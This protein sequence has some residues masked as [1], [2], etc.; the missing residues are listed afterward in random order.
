MSSVASNPQFGKWCG[1]CVCWN[2]GFVGCRRWDS[3]EGVRIETLMD[4]GATKTK[5]ITEPTLLSVCVVR[6][7][8]TEASRM[9][10]FFPSHKRFQIPLPRDETPPR[11][12]LAA[13]SHRPSRRPP[14]RR[15]WRRRTPKRRRRTTRRRR[16]PGRTSIP[17]TRRRRRRRSLPRR[18]SLLIR[19]GIGALGGD[20]NVFLFSWR[21]LERLLVEQR[22]S[23]LGGI[24]RGVFSWS[25]GRVN[26]G[27]LTCLLV[28]TLALLVGT[29]AFLVGAVSVLHEVVLQLRKISKK[30]LECALLPES[31]IVV[32]LSRTRG[33]ARTVTGNDCRPDLICSPVPV[34]HIQRPHPHKPLG[35]RLCVQTSVGTKIVRLVQ[36]KVLQRD[37]PH[38]GRGLLVF[39]EQFLDVWLSQGQVYKG[40]CSRST[41]VGLLWT[42]NLQVEN[43]HGATAALLFEGIEVLILR[44]ISMPTRSVC[45]RK[46]QFLASL[47]IRNADHQRGPPSREQSGAISLPRGEQREAIFLSMAVVGRGTRIIRSVSSRPPAHVQLFIR[48]CARSCL[49]KN[50]ESPGV[51]VLCTQIPWCPRALELPDVV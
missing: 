47:M 44:K 35:R 16:T 18:S 10:S 8:G 19:G 33:A 32:E 28:E 37:V 3:F 51:P 29:V 24:W 26:W 42:N 25:S 43:R 30:M 1:V 22:A 11:T 40:S 13:S 2:G 36:V 38:A 27:D 17:T 46:A 39:I 5:N 14:P 4:H 50:T 21:H 41:T 12:S 48:W 31:E 49:H 7:V 9:F 15:N 45:F 23:K 6:F 34:L 20:W